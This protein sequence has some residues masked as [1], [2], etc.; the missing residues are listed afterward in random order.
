MYTLQDEISYDSYPAKITRTYKNTLT[1]NTLMTYLLKEDAHGNKWWTFE[2][3]YS[4]PLI[5]Q[6]AASKVTQLF[7][8]DLLLEDVLTICDQ[9]KDIAKGNAK[10]KYE[11]TYAKWLELES[12][13]K[14]MAD[15]VKQYTALCTLYLL[16]ND[17]GP[18][19]YSQANQ[20]K[21]MDVLSVDIGL[22]TFF[23]TWWSEVIGRFG[24][25]FSGLSQIASNLMTSQSDIPE[26]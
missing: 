2:D 22:Q 25:D 20:N 17:E 13:A 23:L 5:R 19:Q 6:M 11:Q 16:L 21:K 8:G 26:P 1:G 10:D 7:G 14:A 4:L 9:G 18:D 24:K 15:P 12:L 3:L